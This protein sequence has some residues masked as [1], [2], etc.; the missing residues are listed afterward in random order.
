MSSTNSSQITQPADKPWT[1]VPE[2]V[3]IAVLL[4][5]LLIAI[6]MIA[7]HILAARAEKLR[8]ASVDTDPID[9]PPLEPYAAGE[10]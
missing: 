5:V 1:Q 6:V 10:A 7:H 3:P 2:A 8:N 4:A 9:D